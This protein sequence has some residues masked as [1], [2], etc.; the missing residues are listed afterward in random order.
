MSEDVKVELGGE[1][2]GFRRA[3][4][5]M[6]QSTKDG[7]RAIESQ[8]GG[9]GGVFDGVRRH[10]TSISMAFSGMA[11]GAGLKSAIEQADAMND[12]AERTGLTVES[13]ARFKFAGEQTGIEIDKVADVLKKL[14]KLMI[15]AGSG[16]EEAALKLSAFGVTLEQIKRSDAEGALKNIAQTI[17][18]L[19]AAARQGGLEL[20]GRGIGVL[21]PML[22]DGAAGLDAM[23]QKADQLKI[24]DGYQASTAAADN[25]NDSLSALKGTLTGVMQ[26]VGGDVLPGITDMTDRFANA[27][28][29]VEEN[30]ET[31]KVLGIAV[32]GGVV[33]NAM[34]QLSMSITASIAGWV[35][36][37]QA[38]RQL[39]TAKV[40]EASA[41]VASAQ[42]VRAHSAML[43][44]EAEAA[45]AS[46]AG[47][48]RLAIVQSALIP[49]RQR[50]TAA[51]ETAV[52]AERALAVAKAESA[53]KTTLTGMALGAL[54]GPLGA[55]IT[56]LGVGATAWMAFGQKGLSSV[57]TVAE[58]IERGREA[59]ARYH[60][61]AKFG[62]G[63]EGQMRASLQAI[64]SQIDLLEESVGKA[65][66]KGASTKLADMK[67]QAQE[68]DTALT[69]IATR[70]ERATKSQEQAQVALAKLTGDLTPG[71]KKK[72]QKGPDSQ[73][74]T[75]DATLA[76]NKN[77]YEQENAGRQFS[78]QQELAYWRDIL[79]IYQVTAKD[80]ESITK[81]TA[82]LELEIRRDAAKKQLDLDASSVEQMQAT[83][84]A[85]VALD[86]ARAQAELDNGLTTKEQFLAQEEQF[87]ARR[88]EIALTALA[89]RIALAEK[90]PTRSPAE[91]ARLYAEVDQLDNQHQIKRIQMSSQ[92]AQES[93][94]IWKDLGERMSGLWDKGVQ[95]L[96]N[97]T[98]TWRNGM[99]A[100][101]AEV[102]GW[103]ARDVVGKQ[104][105]LWILGEASKT[106]ATQTGIAVR[107]AAEAAAS[108]KS[109]GLWAMTAVK[110]IMTTA[111]EAMAAAWKA[112]VGI[113]VIGPVLAPIAA[114]AAFAGV[115]ALAKN[116]MSAEGGYD[117][118]RGINPLT[119][120][121]EQEM[122]LPKEDANVIRS[123]RG[124]DASAG[125]GGGVTVNYHDHS[126]RLTLAE[127]QRNAGNIVKVLNDQA[128]N[129][130]FSR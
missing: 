10:I 123:L 106:G 34:R 130:A 95:A 29:A 20:L 21:V 83:A 18:A 73:M 3:M 40:A 31:L 109:I 27:T 37:T 46:A 41:T 44:A 99:Q 77:K 80:Q 30:R 117:I 43:L 64:R 4:Q 24:T 53:A 128:R 23:F 126:G 94:Q 6:V 15:E 33:T 107:G 98:L 56:L 19:P 102:V 100:V 71:E 42:A 48:A 9:L 68:L 62:T 105:K 57:K 114:G 101:G 22:K 45:V 129:F 72:G 104:V 103:F 50:M 5:E 88:H 75:Y 16:N 85:Q 116:V 12:L 25:F 28:L 58:E 125:S 59:L 127:I 14:S 121:H 87:E 122:V 52:I 17:A 91:I 11:F 54:G 8:F 119:Q 55:I 1:I 60:R 113:P 47:M 66:S 35:T 89:Q 61:E 7:T 49:A 32:I 13:L 38:V 78:K 124:G 63:D 39:M 67:A 110:N 86:Q 26:R 92:M 65:G 2:T 120:L 108:L 69:E 70:R 76:V 51:T 93:G 81:R 115:S 111:W 36:S 82:V 118:P 84:T 90:D 112:V 79:N 74:S 96:M 97:G